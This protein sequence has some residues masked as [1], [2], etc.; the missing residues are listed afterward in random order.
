MEKGGR[1]K[2]VAEEYRGLR[3]LGHDVS[4]V[5]FCEPPSWVREQHDPQGDWLVCPKSDA[6]IDFRLLRRLNE[7]IRDFRPQLIDAH[8]EASALYAGL[9]G[10]LSGVRCV[11]TV[12]RS[13]LSY[14]ERSWKSRLYF[15]FTD[16]VIAVSRQRG[17][18]IA[19]ALGLPPSRVEV[20]HWGIATE[21]APA[22]SSR[23]EA[24]AQLG[25]GDGP[26]LLSIGHLGAIKGHDDSIASLKNV[27]AVHPQ[28]RLYIAGDGGDAD[29]S[30][31]RATAEQEGVSEAVVLLGQTS[32]VITWLR[33]CDVF[34]QPSR[35]EAFGLVFLEAGLCE[36]P[37]VATRIGGIPEIIDDGRTGLL[38]APGAPGQIAEAVLQLLNAPD[39]AEAMGSAARTRIAQFFDLGDRVGALATFFSRVA[40][41]A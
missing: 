37:T 25:L 23:A 9:V 7:L 33:A 27:L 32:N 22:L 2:R 31:L 36:R 1:T 39:L 41:A 20:V 4:L 13:N 21:Q 30:R 24:R 38:V 18:L 5:T 16:H 3:E 35:E 26:I 10:R 19:D 14:Y 40:S 12:H 11:A 29:Y 6:A 8:C 15:R 28:A 34:L 17:Q